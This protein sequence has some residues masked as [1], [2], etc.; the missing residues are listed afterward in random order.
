VRT[1]YR[2]ACIKRDNWPDTKR[3]ARRLIADPARYGAT[4]RER[5]I[6]ADLLAQAE[7]TR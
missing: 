1:T 2:P 5:A 3:W 7:V 4:E 6:V